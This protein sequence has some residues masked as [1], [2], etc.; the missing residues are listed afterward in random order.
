[1][2]QE[3]VPKLLSESGW[4]DGVY[5]EFVANLHKFMAIITEQSYLRLG[6]TFLYIPNED[7]SDIDTAQLDKDLIQRLE[8]TIIGWTR[9]IKE[10]VSSQDGSTGSE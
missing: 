3:Y 7:L 9:Q 6:K 2:N 10:L 5:K 1:M 4:P 8:Q